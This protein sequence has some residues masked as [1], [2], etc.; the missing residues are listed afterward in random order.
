MPVADLSKIEVKG[1]EIGGKAQTLAMSPRGNKLA[2]TFKDTN[3]VAV[4]SV[5]TGKFLLNLTAFG[6]INGLGNEFPSTICFRKDNENCL[7]IGW[8]SG[9]VQYFSFS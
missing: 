6:V 9:R 8:S 7:S 5:S 1:M 3:A 4:F 2:V